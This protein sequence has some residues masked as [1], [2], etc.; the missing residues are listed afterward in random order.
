M[1]FQKLASA[2]RNDVVSGLRG[3]HTNMSM[4][5]EQLEDD[6][7]DERLQIIKEYSLKGILP[8]KDLL[9]SINCIDVDCKSL[10]RCKCQGSACDTLV[11]HFEIPQLLNDYGRMAIDYIGS[12]DRQVPFTYYTSS[13]M[14]NYHK[15]RKRGKHKPYVWIDT[16]PNENGMYDCFIFNAPLIKQ[17]SVVAIFKDP[18]QLENYHCCEP[19][20]DDNFTFLNNE[21]KRR[22][23]EKKLRYYRQLAAPLLPNDQTYTAG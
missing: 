12:V 2:I 14:S 13:V 7:V 17:V 6:I 19:F 4:S 22:L 18:R 9:L 10:E 8:I 11:A 23:T 21:I 3:Y 1:I 16:T 15:Y 20:Q 5:L